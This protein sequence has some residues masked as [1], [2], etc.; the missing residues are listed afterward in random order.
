MNDAQLDFQV[1]DTD[2]RQGEI[3]LQAVYDFIGRFVSYPSDHARVAHTL[4]IAHTH[5]MSAWDTTPR[6][7]FM[8]AE[9]ESAR[10]EL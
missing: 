10:P 5:R 6:L 9:K 7:A 8:S 4:W 2:A 3:M 1:L